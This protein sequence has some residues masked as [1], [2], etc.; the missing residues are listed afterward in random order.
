M[1]RA[2]RVLSGLGCSTVPQSASQSM[3]RAIAPPALHTAPMPTLPYHRVKADLETP[4]RL[5]DVSGTA[6]GLKFGTVVSQ[7]LIVL[8]WD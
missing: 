6:S 5:V 3:T 1:A 2:D 8:W 7:I 4:D